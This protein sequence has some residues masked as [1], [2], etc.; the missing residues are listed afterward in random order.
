MFFSDLQNVDNFFFQ[1]CQTNHD[2][3]EKQ[4]VLHDDLYQI[5]EILSLSDALLHA[6]SLI[7]LLHFFATTTI[8]QS[9]QGYI[10]ADGFVLMHYFPMLISILS[11]S[12]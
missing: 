8:F 12:T 4:S 2:F 5:V 6:H 10:R 1:K 3:I 9:N 7:E 11:I